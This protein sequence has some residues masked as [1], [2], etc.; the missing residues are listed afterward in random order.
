MSCRR[1]I[2]RRRRRVDVPHRDEGHRDIQVAGGGEAHAV[3]VRAVVARRAVLMILVVLRPDPRIFMAVLAMT[4]VLVRGRGGGRFVVDLAVAQDTDRRLSGG[5]SVS[6]QEQK[7]D[8]AKEAS[9]ACV[10]ASEH[11]P[12]VMGSGTGL[13]LGPRPCASL[14]GG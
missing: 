14:T 6:H 12:R 10:Y 13:H 11:D 4:R 2:G 9:P 8:A 5:G 7:R 3:S 1:A